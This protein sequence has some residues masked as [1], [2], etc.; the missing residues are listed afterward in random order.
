MRKIYLFAVFLLAFALACSSD[1]N[2][3]N[4]SVPLPA[5]LTT[6]AVSTDTPT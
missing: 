2:N 4:N 5:S 3:T 6:L 1:D